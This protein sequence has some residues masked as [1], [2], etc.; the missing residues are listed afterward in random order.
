MPKIIQGKPQSAQHDGKCEALRAK[1]THIA[2]VSPDAVLRDPIEPE[3]M[4]LDRE[5]TDVLEI[6]EV[7]GELTSNPFEIGKKIAY[8]EFVCEFSLNLEAD[9]TNLINYLNYT[10]EQFSAVFVT[11]DKTAYFFG[12][13]TA[14][15]P[16]NFKLRKAIPRGNAELGEIQGTI[17]CNAFSCSIQKGVKLASFNVTTPDLIV[18]AQYP[19]NLVM[20]GGNNLLVQKGELTYIYAM[21]GKNTVTALRFNEALVEGD[22]LLDDSWTGLQAVELKNGNDLNLTLGSFIRKA[23]FTLDM[24]NA[25]LQKDKLLSVLQQLNTIGSDLTFTGRTF[26]IGVLVSDFGFESSAQGFPLIPGGA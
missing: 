20:E 15:Q 16:M 10:R 13:D 14:Y 8:G 12:E 9:Y 26:K 5:S 6:M 4:Y 19:E 21:D 17:T 3:N 24:T 1:I 25:I 22:V 11:Q 18:K 7:A 2:I 23:G